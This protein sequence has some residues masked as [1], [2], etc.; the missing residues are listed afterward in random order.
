MIKVLEN[1]KEIHL[2]ESTYSIAIYLL[3]KKYNMFE[4]IPIY[5]HTYVRNN[6]NMNIYIKP[7]FKY[8]IL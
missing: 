5:F 8:T 4:N 7:Q 3:Q 2:I 1:A 6:R